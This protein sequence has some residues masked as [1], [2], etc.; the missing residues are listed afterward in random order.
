MGNN[1]TTPL[2]PDS[3][4]GEFRSRVG[5]AMGYVQYLSLSD[6]LITTLLSADVRTGFV[7]FDRSLTSIIQVP[8]CGA[9]VCRTHYRLDAKCTFHCDAYI[10]S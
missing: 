1:E 6:V 5:I 8:S 9:T 2:R 4:L 10:I 7:G 3:L